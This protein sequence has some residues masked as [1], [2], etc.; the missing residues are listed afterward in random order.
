M[1]QYKIIFSGSVGA[2]KSTAIKVIS[3]IEVVATEARAS[4]H[5]Q[6]MKE[7]TT[8]AMDYGRINLDAETTVH[9]YGTPGQERFSFM[10]E[11]L[12]QGALGLVLLID[13]SATA[14]KTDINRYLAAFKDFIKENAVVIGLTRSDL[15][16]GIDWE[17][18]YDTLAEN[19]I[20]APVFEVDARNK[21]DI[22]MLVEALVLSIDPTID[23]TINPV[24]T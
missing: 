24:V 5:I 22:N 12:A 18:I 17:M 11:I 19:D 6:K 9:L 3:D 21:T 13:C 8:V 23:S 20:S 15:S 4:D 14:I 16:T 10:W 1:Q 7:S 2:G